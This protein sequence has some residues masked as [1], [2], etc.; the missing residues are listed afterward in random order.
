MRQRN[1]ASLSHEERYTWSVFHAATCLITAAS[2]IELAIDLIRRSPSGLLRGRH[3]VR[4]D[5]WLDYH[6][7]HFASS[8]VSLQDATILLIAEVYQLGL[9]PRYCT[10]DVLASHRHVRATAA[11]KALKALDKVGAPHR[12]RRNVYLH[13]AEEAGLGL[14]VGEECAHNVQ[15]LA[16]INSSSAKSSESLDD[17]RYAWR[18]LL[19]LA[20]P[21]VKAAR[22]E[23]VAATTRVLDALSK[24]YTLRADALRQLSGNA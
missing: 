5:V 21:Q 6:L 7:S 15:G 14:Y 11:V 13:R 18:V 2:R 3:Q 10:L 16:L 8:L 1:A 17:E 24:E 12:T 9:A 22:H 23:A 4:R 20:L 19:R